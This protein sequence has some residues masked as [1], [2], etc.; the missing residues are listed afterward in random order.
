MT[1]DGHGNFVSNIQ[2]IDNIFNKRMLL[3]DMNGES[4]G[5]IIKGSE[6]FRDTDMILV[7]ALGLR[8]VALRISALQLICQNRSRGHN[9]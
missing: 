4:L 8:G 6:V 3:E 5:K 9:S 2:L 7:T 1:N